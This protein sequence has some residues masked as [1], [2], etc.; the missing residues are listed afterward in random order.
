MIKKAQIF[1]CLFMIVNSCHYNLRA[2][3]H[4]IHLT[5]QVIQLNNPG[6]VF[7]EILT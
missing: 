3:I 7:G 1:T 4:L 2:D 5:A 6:R